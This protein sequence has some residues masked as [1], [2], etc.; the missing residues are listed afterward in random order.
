MNANVRELEKRDLRKFMGKKRGR[1]F[2][3]L[4]SG[5]MPLPHF[6]SSYSQDCYTASAMEIL[7]AILCWGWLWT[8]LLWRAIASYSIYK[9]VLVG[10]TTRDAVFFILLQGGI[11]LVVAFVYGKAI[12]LNAGEIITEMMFI[13]TGMSNLFFGIKSMA[14]LRNKKISG[15]DD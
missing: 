2:Q 5:R 13:A 11:Y 3:P 12:K 10:K 8:L 9:E 4:A 1:G 14:I 15:S 6:P 7:T